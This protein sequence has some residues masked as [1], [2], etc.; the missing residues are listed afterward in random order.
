[1]SSSGDGEPAGRCALV[2]G[3]GS[4]IGA[5]CARALAGAGA[6]VALAGRRMDV[7]QAVASEIAAG[8]G[9]ALAFSC[10]VTNPDQVNAAFGFFSAALGPIEI[11]VNAAGQ[12]HSA[13][14][15]QTS[16][17]DVDR[18]L[19]VNLRGAW[20]TARAA[21]PAMKRAKFGRIVNVASTAA[22]R[23]YRFNAL[24][25]ASKHALAGL[26]RSLSAELL[27]HGVTVNAVCPGFTDTD[28]VKDAARSIA[29]KTGR[30]EAEAVA[31]L[32]TQ[33]PIGRLV[34]PEEV[35]AAVLWLVGDGGASVSGQ[36][37]V[38]DGG[39]VQV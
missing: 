13:T 3:A 38:I 33:N 6:R 22:V 36:S 35:A 12:S 23:G 26:T 27:P 17:A 24:Y 21:A 14:L 25:T 11:V 1:M 2:T 18:I 30:S 39:T 4:G 15:A 10:D 7:L 20:H 31:A 9:E 37:I 19:S 28:L 29:E 32:A 5:A 34:T 16:D 8:E